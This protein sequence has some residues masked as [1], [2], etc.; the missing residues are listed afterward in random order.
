MLLPGTDGLEAQ[1]HHQHTTAREAP[2]TESTYHS[3]TQTHL[4]KASAIALTVI[5]PLILA[6]VCKH[7]MGS[8]AEDL[9]P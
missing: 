2:S 9:L 8:Q 4:Q 7:N 3:T 6:F 5:I 1:S